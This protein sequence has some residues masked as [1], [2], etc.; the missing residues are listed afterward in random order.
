MFITNLLLIIHYTYFAITNTK[1]DYTVTFTIHYFALLYVSN[2]PTDNLHRIYSNN[3][4]IMD[5]GEYA[6]F[7]SNIPGG[8]DNVQRSGKD[9]RNLSSSS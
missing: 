7:T 1:I 4:A 2:M 5:D 9:I 8:G 6:K 3:G